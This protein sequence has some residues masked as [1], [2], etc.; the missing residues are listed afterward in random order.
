MLRGAVLLAA[1]GVAIGLVS[2]VILTRVFQAQ[3]P[4]FQITGTD[5]LT[6]GSVCVL[7]A[8]VTLLASFVP[9]WKV[10]RQSPVKTLN[11]G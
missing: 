7:L 4:L 1:S 6:L 5:P 2:A 3:L 10:G 9:V 8:G 11:E